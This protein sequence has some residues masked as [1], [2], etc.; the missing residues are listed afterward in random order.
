M[1]G[2][3]DR[4]SPLQ[5]KCLLVMHHLLQSRLVANKQRNPSSVS[6]RL[7]MR[8]RQL[9]LDSARGGDRGP[10]EPVVRYGHARDG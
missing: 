2:E 3:E 1:E 4:T 8:K 6:W 10:Q 9:D 5:L 7:L